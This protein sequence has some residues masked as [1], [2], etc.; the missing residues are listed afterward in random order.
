MGAWHG[1]VCHSRYYN[2]YSEDDLDMNLRM[3]MGMARYWRPIAYVRR[4]RLTE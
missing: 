4:L 2:S 1:I 3:E